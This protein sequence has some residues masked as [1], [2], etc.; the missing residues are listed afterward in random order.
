MLGER[1]DAERSGWTLAYDGFDPA[2]E[3][4]REALTSPGNGYFCTRGAAEWS[5]GGSVHYPGTYTH[6]GFILGSGLAGFVNTFNPE[7][8]AVGGGASRAGEFLLEPARK[9]VHLRAK[10][11]SRYL[12]QTKEATL[13]PESGVLGAAALARNE[14]GEYVLELSQGLA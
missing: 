3:G 2:D 12:V 11:P 6:C 1:K 5:E 14:D 9:E 10:S 4:L 13:G 7:V 8:V